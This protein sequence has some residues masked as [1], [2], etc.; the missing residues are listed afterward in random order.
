[1]KHG[2]V[3]LLLLFLGTCSAYTYKNV[4]LRGKATQSYRNQ[5][6]P[7]SV[8]GAASNAIDG[9]RESNYKAGSCSHTTAQT[10]PWWRVDLLE[11]YV[12]TSII[13]TNR[14]D[15]CADRISGAEIHIGNSLRDNGARN[16]VVSVI[17][18]IPA[19][20]SYT[21]TVTKHVEGRYV[22]VVLPGKGRMLTLC[23]VEVYGYRAPTGENMA[24]QGKASQSSLY[25]YL[26]N[27]Y[28]AIDGSRDSKLSDG[29][30][31]YTKYTPSPWWRVD[32]QKTHKVF[33]VKITNEATY[34]KRLDGAEI[35]I[36]DSSVNN[37][38][39]NPRCAVI[40][41]IPGG[42]TQTFDCKGMEG[43][44]VSIVIPGKTQYLTLCEVEVYGSELD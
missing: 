15:C 17:P 20:R 21:V 39:S 29:S 42:F 23:E 41:H 8:F 26:G 14:G 22:T 13:I 32:L 12:V 34:P 9:N 28:N 27:P 2:S 40:T 38:N 43:R 44:Y 24:L 1:M 16:P 3:L 30:C 5:G 35:R 10:N 31:T 18:R 7:W 25:S 4:A 6:S 37:G 36:G 19:G 11:S 33:S